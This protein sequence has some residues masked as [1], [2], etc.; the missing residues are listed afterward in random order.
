VCLCPIEETETLN[1]REGILNYVCTTQEPLQIVKIRH[2][3]E[4]AEPT[5]SDVNINRMLCVLIN[6]VA[7]SRELKGGLSAPTESNPIKSARI[8]WVFSNL[9]RRTSK[10]LCR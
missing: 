6:R 5:Y 9:K 4:Q 8:Q 2:V 1:N 7:S 10:E 3:Y